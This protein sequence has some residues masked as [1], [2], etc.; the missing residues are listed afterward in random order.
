MLL[1][2]YFM[3]RSDPMIRE[4]AMAVLVDFC[5]TKLR[6][7]KKVLWALPWENLRLFMLSKKS[8]LIIP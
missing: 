3:H 4:R 1:T 7:Q 6:F 8:N 2:F 5:H